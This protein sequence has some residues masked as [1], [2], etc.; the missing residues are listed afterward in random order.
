MQGSLVG[1]NEAVESLANLN[2]GKVNY[3]TET[4]TDAKALLEEAREPRLP[5]FEPATRH[6]EVRTRCAS[7]V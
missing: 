3:R 6:E 4:A 5:V 7:F 1:G 2:K